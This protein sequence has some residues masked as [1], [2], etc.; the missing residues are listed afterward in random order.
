MDEIYQAHTLSIQSGTYPCAVPGAVFR[1]AVGS[2]S[3]EGFPPQFSPV[4]PLCP[5]PDCKRPARD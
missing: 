3:F 5:P 1:A 4:G 2:V